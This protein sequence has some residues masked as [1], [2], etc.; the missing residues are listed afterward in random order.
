MITSETPP[1]EGQSRIDPERRARSIVTGTIVAVVVALWGLF[2]LW[3]Y[4]LRADHHRAMAQVLDRQRVAVGELVNGIFTTTQAFLV[5]VDHWV[6]DHPDR[7]PRADPDFADLVH[8]FQRVTN[9]GMTF[10]LIDADGGFHVVP[11]TP[12]VKPANVADRDYF[13]GAMNKPPGEMFISAPYLGRAT[14]H[15]AI[16]V[17]TRLTRPSHGISIASVAIELE[18]FETAFARTRIGEDSTIALIRRDGIMLARSAANPIE[19]GKDVSKAIIFA[20]GL[21]K[22]D[23]GVLINDSR[24]VDGIPKLTAFGAMAS[25]PLVVV[26]GVS[27]K[28]IDAEIRQPVLSAAVIMVLFTLAALGSRS[29]IIRLL[30]EVGRGRQRLTAEIDVRRRVETAL[31]RSE[32]DFRAILDNMLDVFYRADAEGRVTML[33][34]SV[35]S[36]LGYQI[37]EVVGRPASDFYVDSAER[38]HL[39]DALGANQGRVTDF[40][41]L[42]R[43]KRG[44]PIWV[45]TSSHL[46]F[47]ADGVVVGVEGVFRCIDERKAVERALRE[48]GA[49][50]ESLLNASSDATM[51]FEADGTLLAV[52]T[53]MAARFGKI[54]AQLTGTCLWDLFP[55]EVAATRRRVV[56]QVLE[57]GE[58]VH[59]FDQRGQYDFDNSIYPVPGADGKAT[60][61]AVYSRDISERK[62][63]E[64]RIARYIAE[65]ER[66]NAELEQFAYVASHDLR[67]PLRMISSYLSLL[68]RRYGDRLDQNGHDFLEFARDGAARMDALV[69]DLLE[70]SRIDRHGAPM[71]PMPARTAIDEALLNL[72]VAIGECGAVVTVENAD[73]PQVT[74]DHG[75][76]MRLFQNVVGNAIKYRAEDRRPE[77]RIGW[78]RAEGGWEFRVA[79]NGIGIDAEYFER[80]FGI[81]QRLHTRD[82]YSGTGIGL[83]VCRK[84]VERHGGRIWLESIPGEGTTFFFTLPDGGEA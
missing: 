75:Q 71:V 17:A 74:G 78:A 57:S 2:G 19:P 46:L 63:D 79:D 33:S 29:K 9:A 44:H 7:D 4:H 69:L 26:A 40:E 45:A 18:V 13:V 35:V 80:I 24:L 83:A 20:E 3:G 8:D 53:V 21:A 84:I 67:E 30:D 1:A 72:S 10:R 49:L 39:L 23:T 73:A 22:A 50:N 82:R 64:A 41:L 11:E 55:P 48:H 66:S 5:A 32:A 59:S 37:D 27:L 76:I 68:Q 51:L 6:A 36:V 77:I 52:N 31:S 54:P 56:A 58:A 28:A 15:R 47:D 34:P 65:I 25:Y 42:M 81:F 61:L 38:Q 62:R 70:Y 43:H 12:S 14:G 60:R 16:A